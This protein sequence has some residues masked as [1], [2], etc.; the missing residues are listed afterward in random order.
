MSGLSPIDTVSLTLEQ[1]RIATDL[2]R[3]ASR[4]CMQAMRDLAMLTDD[5]RQD[6]VVAAYAIAALT[7]FAAGSLECIGPDGKA[8]PLP[9]TPSREAMQAVLDYVGEVLV[10]L[11]LNTGETA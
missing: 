2:G 10:P 6:F 3:E 7:G 11:A 5:H 4:R 1:E 9:E 8:R